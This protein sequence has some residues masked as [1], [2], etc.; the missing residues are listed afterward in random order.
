MSGTRPVERPLDRYS[1]TGRNCG[2]SLLPPFPPLGDLP[3]SQ[4]KISLLEVP[5]RI[6][7]QLVKPYRRITRQ[8]RDGSSRGPS[9]VSPRQIPWNQAAHVT[10]TIM[11]AE[12]C[13]EIRPRSF[14]SLAG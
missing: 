10:G 6:R 5:Q 11:V 9:R 8:T 13:D 14:G 1:Q 4:R 7:N 3:P 2:Q 12:P